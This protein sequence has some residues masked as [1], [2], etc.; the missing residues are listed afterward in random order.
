MKFKLLITA[1]ALAMTQVVFAADYPPRPTQCPPITSLQNVGVSDTYHLR[2]PDGGVLTGI[3]RHNYFNTD[4]EWT[5]LVG[6][7]NTATPKNKVLAKANDLLSDLVYVE[8][9][10]QERDGLWACG[11][12]HRSDTEHS[13][14]GFVAWAIYPALDIPSSMLKGILKK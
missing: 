2:D 4:V 11:Y 6:I 8:G 3:E 14:K 10:V 12:K 7:F 1:L 9:P 13:D 5:L